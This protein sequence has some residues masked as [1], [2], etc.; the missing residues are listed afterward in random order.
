MWKLFVM[1]FLTVFASFAHAQPGRQNNQLGRQA[2]RTKVNQVYA[3]IVVNHMNVA[4]LADM[5]GGSIIDENNY[6][7]G[8]S[9]GGGYGN[10]GNSGS[11]GNSGNSNNSGGYGRSSSGGNRSGGYGR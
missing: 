11:Y 6:L 1:A 4:M 8:G 9:N 3:V 7:G 5:F 2:N 10:S